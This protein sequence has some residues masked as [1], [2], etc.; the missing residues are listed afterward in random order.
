MKKL[1]YESPH[2]EEVLLKFEDNLLAQFSRTI[3]A[4]PFVG[5]DSEEENW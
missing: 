2:V 3:T 1:C 4:S 5:F